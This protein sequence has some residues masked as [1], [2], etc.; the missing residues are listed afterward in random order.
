M[1]IG[2]FNSVAPIELQLTDYSCSVGATY[3]CLR[4]VGVDIT[5]QSLQ[6]MMVPSIVSPDLGL[7][8]SSG[9]AI[10]RLLRE[11]FGL[12]AQNVPLI[13]FDEVGGRAGRQ[14]LAIGGR[15]WFTNPGTGSTTGHWVAVRRF[16]DDQII[17]ANPGGTGPNFG[18]QALDRDSFARRG[19]FS[20]VWIDV[21]GTFSGDGD[22]AVGLRFAIG[23]TDGQGANVRKEPASGAALVTALREGANVRGDEHAWRQVTDESGAQGWLADEFLEP[24]G[25]RF[26]VVRT[27]GQ[28]ANMR[29]EPDV[30]GPRVKLVAEGTELAGDEHAWR[31]ITTGDGS[32][33]WVA[34]SFLVAQG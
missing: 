21:D 10:A 14:P 13:S 3:W 16:E 15:R 4:S 22:S 9:V 29:G 18:Q 8:D 1:P 5:Q 25:A 33:G 26:R 6:D 17:L 11:R 34:N 20:A 32:T 7:L 31:R 2:L 24:A 19:T 30:G 23:N 12:P 28:G 27:D